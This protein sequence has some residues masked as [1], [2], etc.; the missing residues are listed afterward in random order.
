MLSIK[1]PSRAAIKTFLQKNE[2]GVFSYP[3]V[4]FSK[5]NDRVAGYDNDLNRAYLG[6][7]E[8]VFKAACGAIRQW[9]MFPGGW[10]SIRPENAPIEVGQTVA[11]IAKVMGLYWL[12][13]CRIVYILEEDKPVRRFGF[14][15][16]TL[17]QHVEK[18]EERFSVEMLPDGS[19]W[20]DLRAY[21]KPRFWMAKVGYPIARRYQR[22]FVEES[23][24][25]M[26]R[27][28]KEGE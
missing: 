13:S 1:S 5:S 14:A 7:G 18:G 24:L 16:G 19:V 23:K 26:Q 2:T 8:A 25:A 12:N 15:Y 27:A 3:E 20:Y 28:V 22:K 10:V 6:K 17:G 21:S 9:K 4:G 11:M